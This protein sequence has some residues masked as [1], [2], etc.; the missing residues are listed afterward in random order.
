MRTPTVPDVITPPVELRTLVGV[1]RTVTPRR[2]RR[3][4]RQLRTLVGAMRTWATRDLYII[5]PGL[6]TLV[7]AMRTRPSTS[8]PRR[9]TRCEPS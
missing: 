5:A 9:R 1:M 2:F 6:R 7:G 8:W 3:S 4:G